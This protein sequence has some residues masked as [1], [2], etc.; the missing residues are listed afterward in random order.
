MAENKTPFLPPSDEEATQLA[1]R[2]RGEETLEVGRSLESLSGLA[3][4]S[5]RALLEELSKD[6]RLADG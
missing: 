1:P 6:G 4:R 5:Y 3:R 2:D